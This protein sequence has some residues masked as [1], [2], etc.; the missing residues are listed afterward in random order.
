[1]ITGWLAYN[2]PMWTDKPPYC[3]TIRFISWGDAAACIKRMHEEK[4]HVSWPLSDEQAVEEFKAVH[5]A[6]DV[7][8]PS[9]WCEE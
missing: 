6:W 8:P 1:M 4:Y 2:D 9:L 5:W 3:N 7:Q